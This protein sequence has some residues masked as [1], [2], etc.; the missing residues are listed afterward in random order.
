MAAA[1]TTGQVEAKSPELRSAGVQR[2][3]H[4][5]HHPL[6]SQVHYGGVSDVEQLGLEPHP[7]W[8]AAV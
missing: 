2:T 3:K 7:I 1:A 6:L 4:V 5:Y 8:L